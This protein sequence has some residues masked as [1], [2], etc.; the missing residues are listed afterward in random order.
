MPKSTLNQKGYPIICSQ[1]YSL[2][3][4]NFHYVYKSGYVLLNILETIKKEIK[5]SLHATTPAR[6]N[7]LNNIKLFK[8]IILN[9][10]VTCTSDIWITKQI[11]NK[12]EKVNILESI[13]K[14]QWINIKELV[15]FYD[16][17]LKRL[18]LD[19]N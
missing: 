4:D 14:R 18:E 15:Q 17:D 19:I 16:L 5:S 12:L 7:I 3:I 8:Q 9:A 11:L 13:S 2:F 6:E 1:N 10:S